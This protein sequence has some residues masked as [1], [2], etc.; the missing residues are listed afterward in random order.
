[1]GGLAEFVDDTPSTEQLHVM[2]VEYEEQT[3]E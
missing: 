2:Q 1:M 3:T